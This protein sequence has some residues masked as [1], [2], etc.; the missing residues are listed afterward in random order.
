MFCLNQGPEI[1]QRLP[2]PQ[3][4]PVNRAMFHNHLFCSCLSFMECSDLFVS[5]ISVPFMKFWRDLYRIIQLRRQKDRHQC[6]GGNTTI[7]KTVGGGS[8]KL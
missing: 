8:G 2:C 3:R 7:I 4:C 6:L 5:N 1:T